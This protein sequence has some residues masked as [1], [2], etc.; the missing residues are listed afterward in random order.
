M[1]VG[2]HKLTMPKW[3]L[4]M[5]EGKV[6]AWLVEDGAEVEAGAE[7]VE[8][9]TE[10]ISSALEAPQSGTLR[11]AAGIGE[12]VPVA[13]LVCV[14]AEASAPASE[15]DAFVAAFQESFVPEEVPEEAAGPA[16]ETLDANGK[17]VRYLRQGDGRE[18]A[19]LIHGF[20]GD[21]NNWLFNHAALSAGRSVYAIDLP[22]HGGSSKQL[23][24]GSLAE[25]TA[26]VVAFLDAVSLPKVHLVGHSMG[27]MVALDLALTHPGR[28]SSLVLLA[29]AGL[30]P[31]IDGGYIEGFI[32]ASR[33]KDM[34]PHLEKLFADPS[35]VS[36]QL[37]D[38]ILKYKRIDGVP[39]ALRTIAAAL[40]PEGRQAVVLRD[41]LGELS[42]PTT[43]LWGDQDRIL[44]ASHA[45]DLPATVKTQVLQGR[46]HMAQMEAPA[47]VNQSI[48]SCWDRSPA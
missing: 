4:A 19:M 28:A 40:F 41:R 35:A 45:Q 15:V 11:R 32:A 34:R 44:P 6:V 31:E 2:I 13:G 23:E 27:G 36:R 12:S 30:G 43:V 48:L 24:N 20:G 22:G 3:G 10:K 5:T 16:P 9:E 33:R 29:P 39:S 14:I 46:G 7:V 47:E 37:I 1:S 21:L 42:L 38:D 26:T 8:I 25:F 18:A 17:T